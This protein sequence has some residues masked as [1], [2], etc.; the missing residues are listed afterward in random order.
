MNKQSMQACLQVLSVRA[1]EIFMHTPPRAQVSNLPYPQ[2]M[3]VCQC[4]YLYFN[5]IIDLHHTL[6]LFSTI[7]LPTEPRWSHV[8]SITRHSVSPRHKLQPSGSLFNQTQSHQSLLAPNSGLG[9]VMACLLVV[10]GPKHLNLTFT[11]PCFTWLLDIF[12]EG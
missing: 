7:L 2:S 4:T 1:S 9:G 6:F 8:Q 3:S 12:I 5:E 11:L 10:T